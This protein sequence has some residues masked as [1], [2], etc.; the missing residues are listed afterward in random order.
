MEQP[1]YITGAGII[2]A[3]GVGKDEVLHSLLKGESGIAP[4][5]HLD[6]IHKHL[7]AGE[8]KWSDAQM[9]EHLGLDSEIGRA[10]CRER[11]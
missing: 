4:L 7:P 3:I 9:R 2:S 5:R 6:T 1:I 10:S 11:V 8:V